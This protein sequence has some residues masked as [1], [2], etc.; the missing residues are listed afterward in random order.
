MSASLKLPA[1]MTVPEFLDWCPED[2]QRWELVDGAPRAMAPAKLGHG[3]I[4]SEIAAL[5]RNHLLDRGQAC[6]VVTAP[7]VIPRVRAATNLRVP[8]LAVTCAPVSPTDATMAEP[9]LIV[10]ILSPSNG[11]ETWANVWTYTTIPSVREILVVHQVAQRAELLRRD[12]RGDWPPEPLTL[13]EGELALDSIGFRVSLAALY[14]TAP[15]L[16]LPG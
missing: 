1:A 5:L 15:P 9:V 8:D 11:A 7:G 4:Q 6:T 10:E 2:G 14:R 13:T 3:A 16:R 12:P